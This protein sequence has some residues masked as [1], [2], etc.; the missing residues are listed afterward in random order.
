ML[1][2]AALSGAW[3][4]VAI[5]MLMGVTDV[6]TVMFAVGVSYTALVHWIEDVK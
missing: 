6:G 5:T 1:V 4:G 3:I 2:Y